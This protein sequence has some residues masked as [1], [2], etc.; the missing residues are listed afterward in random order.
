MSSVTGAVLLERVAQRIVAAYLKKAGYGDVRVVTGGST[1]AGV[2]IVYTVSGR[3][4]RIKLKSDSYFGTD[5]AKVSDRDL[6]FYRPD[7][8]HY[9]F[10]S[11]SNNM[12]REPGWMFNSEAD[13]LYY[14]Y[15]TLSQP[16]DEVAALLSEPDEVFFSEIKVERDALHILP[17][18]ATQKWFEAHYEDYTPRPVTVGQHSAWYRLIPRSDIEGS[19]QGA[20][21]VGSVFKTVAS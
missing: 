6:V 4:G 10:E 19:I 20:R 5:P 17:M 7:A 18:R 13:D 2:D 3:R 14:Y 12:T 8:G 21:L 16:E 1:G 9:A 15:L 11:I